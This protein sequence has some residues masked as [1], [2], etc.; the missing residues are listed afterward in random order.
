MAAP[1]VPDGIEYPPLSE[2][3]KK[4]GVCTIIGFGS[5]LSGQASRR[6][7]GSSTLELIVS[8]NS[9]AHSP[10]L[11]LCSA[12]SEKSCRFTFSTV[13]NFRPG[14]ICGWRRVFGHVAPIFLERGIANVE[15]KEMSSLSVEPAEETVQMRVSVFE[16][17]SPNK[18]GTAIPRT[19][20]RYSFFSLSNIQDPHRRSSRL[21]PARDGVPVATHVRLYTARPVSR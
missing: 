21:L 18:A 9:S 10:L 2:A 5:L 15:T 14:S 8:W 19:R 20:R 13:L 1:A 11:P 6:R 12:G 16:V 17:R 7:H 4:A 3:A